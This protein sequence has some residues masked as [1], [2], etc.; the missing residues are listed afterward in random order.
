MLG[1]SRGGAEGGVRAFVNP[2]IFC[3]GRGQ[4]RGVLGACQGF[5]E[6]A[7]FSVGAWWGC[8]GGVLGTRQ[9]CVGG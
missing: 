8:V 5:C 6:P 2:P 1:A 4:V 9:G 7:D 3:G